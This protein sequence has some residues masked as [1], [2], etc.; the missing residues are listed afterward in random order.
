MITNEALM[1]VIYKE[2]WEVKVDRVVFT[3]NEKQLAILKKAIL[4]GQHGMVW[5]NAFA[6]SIPHISCISLRSRER[7][8]LKLARPEAIVNQ[9]EKELADKKLNEIRNKYPFINREKKI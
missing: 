2:E 8:Q 6:I 1:P 5:F 9:V 7:N 4:D 3:L